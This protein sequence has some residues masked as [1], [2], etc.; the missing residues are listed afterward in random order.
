[1]FLYNTELF[2]IELFLDLIVCKQK[3]V[4]MYAK[5]NFFKNRI[6]FTFNSV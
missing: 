2:A 1:M 5:L 6:V 3:N 4:R